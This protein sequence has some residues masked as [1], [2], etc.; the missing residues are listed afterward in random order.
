M[1]RQRVPA[2][3]RSQTARVRQGLLRPHVTVFAVEDRA[4]QLTWP[5]LP[6]PSVTLEVGPQKVE[7]DASEPAFL[8]RVGRPPRRLSL[9]VSLGWP[10]PDYAA[11]GVGGPGS[12]VIDELEPATAYDVL[13]SGEGLAARAVASFTTLPSPP[14]RL[15]ARFATVNDIHIGDRGFGGLHTIDDVAPLPEGWEPFP[16][17]CARAAIEEAT[18]WG[19]ELLVVKGD[20]TRE[21]EPVEFHET[22]RLL[23]TSPIPVAAILG[24]HDVRGGVDGRAILA[25]HGIDVPPGAW[26]L[27]L[28]GLRIVGGHT[29]IP[30]RHRGELTPTQRRELVRLAE[31]GGG[32]AF[33]AIHHQLQLT[34][35]AHYYPP[36]VPQEESR[37]FLEE[38]AIACPAAMVASGHTHRNRRHRFGPL[39]MVE[40]GSTKDYPGQWAGY[41]VHEGGIRQVVRR[42]AAPSVLGWTEPSALALGGVWGRWSVGT[43]DDRCFTICWPDR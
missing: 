42:I 29:P 8:R 41:A 28:P 21:S 6:A 38:L 4:V 20:M 5:C 7:I 37:R 34:R 15:L 32:P 23:A 11:P 18:A 13:V 3:I 24:N 25:E 19:A 43:L 26:S 27:D 9:P 40:V 31:E 33:V 2:T 39:T 36:G 16:L 30:T 17:R 14:G 10:V 22:G 35:W 1:I 12:V